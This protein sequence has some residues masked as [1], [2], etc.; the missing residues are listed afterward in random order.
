MLTIK[1]LPDKLYV[2]TILAFEHCPYLTLLKLCHR[3][4]ELFFKKN[5]VN[6]NQK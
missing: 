3:F 2:T 4:A 1:N 5:W 6:I